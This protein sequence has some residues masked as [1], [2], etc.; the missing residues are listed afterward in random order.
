MRKLGATEKLVIYILSKKEWLSTKEIVGLLGKIKKS[1]PAVRATLFRLKNKNLIKDL[2]KGRETLFSLADSGKEFI[3]GYMNRISMAEKT[4][5]GKWLLF[6]FNIPEK[7]RRLRNILRNELIFHGFGRLHANL[8]ISPHDLREECNKIIDRLNVK[9]CTAMFITDYVGDDPKTLA[10]RVWNLDRL[11][12][13]YEKASEKYS[14]QYEEF[15]KSKSSDSSQGALEALVRLLKLKEEVIE[16]GLKDP[17]LPKELLPDN[18][19]GFRLKT[20]VL[21][22]LQFL[23]QISYPLVGFDYQAGKHFKKEGRT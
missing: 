7:K 4:W 11:L 16:L 17:H 13:T 1:E 12:K 20:V 18:W 14:N 10:Y 5:D 2:Q 9:D 6:S 19:V 21:G 3:S 23:Y 15:K 22:Y 8:W